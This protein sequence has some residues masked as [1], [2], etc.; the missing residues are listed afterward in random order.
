MKKE[1]PIKREVLRYLGYQDQVIDPISHSMID[2]AIEEIGSLIEK[3]AIYKNFPISFQKDKV[4]LE[5]TDLKLVG[6]DI[7]NHLKDSCTCILMAVTLGHRVD[8]RIRYYEKIDMTRALILD[9][10]ATGFIEKACNDICKDIERELDGDKALTNRFSPGYGDLG[11][12]IQ[13]K[14]LNIL[15]AQKTIG[16][17]ISSSSILTPRK[18]VTAIVGIIDKDKRKERKCIDCNK[19]LQ[20]DFKKEEEACGS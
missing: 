9:A 7:Q 5:G 13:G 15:G 4:L 18:S 8:T 14:F 10:A 2:E 6:K 3:R 20:C 19:Y 17:N 1:E 16:L 12:H 11:I